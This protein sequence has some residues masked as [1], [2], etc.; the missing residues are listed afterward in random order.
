MVEFD[1]PI[2]AS[3]IEDI[4]KSPSNRSIIKMEENSKYCIVFEKTAWHIV[5]DSEAIPR[6]ISAIIPN[7]IQHCQDIPKQEL[8]KRGLHERW[9]AL[10]LFL[11]L[12]VNG[13]DNAIRSLASDFKNILFKLTKKYYIQ[14]DNNI[15]CLHPNTISV[16]QNE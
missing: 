3:I 5:P 14:S 2:I 6:F 8:L 12:V 4:W 15:I 10:M 13:D 11:A 16:T 7:I 9:S 1:E